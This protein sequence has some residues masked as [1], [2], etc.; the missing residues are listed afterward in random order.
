MNYQIIHQLTLLLLGECSIVILHYYCAIFWLFFLH[1][2]DFITKFVGKYTMKFCIF[3][4][5]WEKY[6][7]IT[8]KLTV[9]KRI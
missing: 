2:S 4:Q 1:I 9:I 6:P 5:F 7:I 8:G 3:L